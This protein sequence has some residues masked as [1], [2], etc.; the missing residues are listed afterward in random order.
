MS[1]LTIMLYNEKR[2]EAFKLSLL[3]AKLRCL[4]FFFLSNNPQKQL[5]YTQSRA[6]DDARVRSVFLRLASDA[7]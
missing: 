4:Q 5:R 1:A 7:P 6:R 3:I 2:T